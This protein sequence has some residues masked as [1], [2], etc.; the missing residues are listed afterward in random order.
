MKQIYQDIDNDALLETMGRS[1]ASSLFR[2]QRIQEI[3]EDS[4]LTE[5]EIQIDALIQQN[6]QLKTDLISLKEDS[7]KLA[8][9]SVNEIT[10]LQATANELNGK[11]NEQGMLTKHLEQENETL[12][13]TVAKLRSQ[14]EGVLNQSEGQSSEMKRSY[15]ETIANLE[16]EIEDMKR[17]RDRVEAEFAERDRMLAE[18]KLDRDALR[19]ELALREENLNIVKHDNNK[20]EGLVKEL[21]HVRE[22]NQAY[23]EEIHHLKEH[24]RTV[25]KELKENQDNLKTK[26]AELS[27]LFLLENQQKTH[28]GKVE[29]MKKK[30]KMKSKKQK[31]DIQELESLNK[32]LTEK[33]SSLRQ[34]LEIERE[35]SAKAK[36]IK[37]DEIRV[38]KLKWEEKLSKQ[39]LEH[40]RVLVKF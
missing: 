25:Q 24:L 34:S 32:T 30:Y 9:A 6:S 5:K 1:E 4:L 36:S 10:S 13:E 39:E 11:L 2:N 31:E 35:Q 21:L 12:R 8:Q 14:Y 27:A 7:H 22:K 17:K 26:N 19:K 16:H 20:L 33:N 28:D 40:Q 23:V 29:D 38:I 37:E 15:R 3:V 18:F